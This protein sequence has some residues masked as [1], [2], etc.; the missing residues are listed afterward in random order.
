MEIY[1]K[2]NGKRALLVGINK[3]SDRKVTNLNFCVN[4]V[5]STH[6][7]LVAPERGGFDPVNCHLMIDYSKEDGSKP[8]RSNLMS[9]IKSISRTAKSNDYLLFFFSGHGIEE[10]GKSY[11]LPAD[12][13]INVLGDTAIP[14]DWIKETMKKSKARAKVLILDACHSSAIKGKAESGRMTKGLHDSIFPA[15]RGFA[16][17]S[18][19]TMN[20]VSYEMPNGKNSVF[21]YFLNE[22][23]KGDADF[24]NDGKITIPD[25]SR[26][27]TEKTLEWA[28]NEGVEQSPTLEYNV[29]RDLILVQVPTRKTD[30][31][32][33]K[34]TPPE[35]L[36]LFQFISRI[37]F[38]FGEPVL[39]RKREDVEIWEEK[40]CAFLLRYYDFAQIKR[41]K[42]IYRF[43][44]GSVNPG[45]GFISFSYNKSHIEL[46]EQIISSYLTLKEK[47]KNLRIFLRKNTSFDSRKIAELEDDTKLVDVRYK[48]EYG[49]LTAALSEKYN[50]GFTKNPIRIIFRNPPFVNEPY[51]IVHLS[52]KKID[53]RTYE[54]IRPSRLFEFLGNIFKLAEKT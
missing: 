53:A 32:E 47:A 17:L 12:A 33:T 22:G 25:A 3:Y 5:T 49:A 27:A 42:N 13:R 43:P 8:I 18:S 14:I 38:F 48:P 21:T 30:L 26:Y 23:L 51:M 9:S 41:V 54:K 11:L 36:D 10:N 19:C 20:Q 24:D 4:D 46:I 39:G 6:E 28:S 15:P 44:H 31:E 16:I 50:K 40:V 7:I 29:V 52:K 35:V 45:I 1:L 2:T 34:V 37:R